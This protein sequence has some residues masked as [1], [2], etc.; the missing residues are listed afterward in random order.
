MANH[1]LSVSQFDKPRI[2]NLFD[3]VERIDQGKPYPRL[4]SNIVSCNLFY[5]P[6]TRTSSSFY[7][8]MVKLGGSVIP[9]NDV[10]FSSVVKGETLEDTIRT[11]ACYS[12]VIVLRHKEQGAAARA[13]Q[14]SHVPVINAGDG[15]GEHPTQAL[16]DLYTIRK[17]VG[18]DRPIRVCLMGDLLH[19][20][21]VHSLVK[22]LRL[23]DVQIHLVSPQKLE[24]PQDL[25][26]PS[27]SIHRTFADCRDEVDVVYVTRVQKERMDPNLYSLLD[28]YKL[29][30]ED[31]DHMKSNSIIM[32]PLPRVDELPH[33]ID[34][35]PRAVYF[36]Q[37]KYGL[38]VRQALFLD[39]LAGVGG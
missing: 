31:L 12:D 20:R 9:I 2:D 7:S 18:L 28:N 10:N 32:H 30:L 22:L 33:E 39:V 15:V 3:M 4:G 34:Q 8:A 29:H 25:T 38:Y 35:D 11:V 27:D 14:V 16:L 21:T 13:A 26:Q 36:L 23:F 6:S 17:H 19:G 1:I 5:E 37:M 24:L